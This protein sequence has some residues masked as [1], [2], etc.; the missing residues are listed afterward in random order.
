M[1]TVCCK[2][3]SLAVLPGSSLD[4]LILNIALN[5]RVVTLKSLLKE[6]NLSTSTSGSSDIPTFTMK[7]ALILLLGATRLLLAADKQPN[8]ESGLKS[9]KSGSH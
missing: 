2:R 6:E 7:V 8:A 1:H 4:F 5:T 3:Y 9:Q